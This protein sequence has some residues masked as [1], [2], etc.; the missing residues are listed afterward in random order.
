MFEE[1]L[2][3]LFTEMRIHAKPVEI[4]MVDEK[5]VEAM[6]LFQGNPRE[7]LIEEDKKILFDYINVCIVRLRLEASFREK[8][9]ISD[10]IGR[11]INQQRRGA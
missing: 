6:E 4:S 11:L 1:I 7:D 8:L 2:R 5:I 3:E 9:R 10:H